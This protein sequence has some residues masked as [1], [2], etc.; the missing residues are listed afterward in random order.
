MNETLREP[1]ELALKCYLQQGVWRKWED[2]FEMTR[3]GAYRF[4]GFQFDNYSIESDTSNYSVLVK[5]T[6]WQSLVDKMHRIFNGKIRSKIL[7][8]TIGHAVRNRVE[9]PK[10][11]SIER[12]QECC[13]EIIE[14]LVQHYETQAEALVP[15]FNI[16]LSGELLYEIPLGRAMFC[17]GN[18]N[19]LLARVVDYSPEVLGF[20]Q[21]S[22]IRECSFLRIPV[23]GDDEH[24]HEQATADAETALAVLRFIT[25]WQTKVDG[26]AKRKN[27]AAFV[28]QWKTEAQKILFHRPA[29]EDITGGHSRILPPLTMA[30]RYIEYGMKLYGLDDLNY[31]FEQ[32]QAHNP[33]SHRVQRALTM[34]DSG[35]QAHSD[36]EALYRYVVSIEIALS[37]K[38]NEGRASLIKKLN[39][40]IFYSEHVGISM[41]KYKECD[42][43]ESTFSRQVRLTVDPLDRF[44]GHRNDI[45]HGNNIDVEAIAENDV[46]EARELAHNAVRL[47][48]KY[49]RKFKWSHKDCM[50]TWFHNCERV[51]NCNWLTEK[52][53]IIIGNQVGYVWTAASELQG[54]HPAKFKQTNGCL[55]RFIKQ[56]GKDRRDRNRLEK[57][58]RELERSG[59]AF[60]C[61]TGISA[62]IADIMATLGDVDL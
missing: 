27:P 40:L 54:K 17:A 45:L 61:E 12:L 5:T 29:D 57:V 49:A 6:A 48:A 16:H 21:N 28:S 7:H 30:E 51:S 44:Y 34:Y 25:V 36:W 56:L 46:E 53:K 59:S 35:T 24:Q 26:L 32:A 2:T 43:E 10:P 33:V 47:L 8:S 20:Q 4:L 42:A 1:C 38:R 22:D 55:D 3:D 39:N 37:T 31:H 18:S 62:R 19:S 9:H 11:F 52:Q 41:R 15:V 50:H 58:V 14:V 13:D 23:S 60:P